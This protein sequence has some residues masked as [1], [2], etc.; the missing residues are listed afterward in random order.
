MGSKVAC[1]ARRRSRLP[2][3]GGLERALDDAR[4]EAIERELMRLAL[5]S[6]GAVHG[7]LFLWDR[8]ARGLVLVH[9][10]VESNPPATP[11]APAAAPANPGACAGSRIAPQRDRRFY[12]PAASRD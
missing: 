5:A 9:H 6:T 3:T 12:E 7:A 10:V 8:K 1:A 11:T 2:E 4:P